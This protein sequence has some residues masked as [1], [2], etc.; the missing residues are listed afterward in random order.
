ML[1]LPHV[2]TRVFGTPL[3]VARPKLE[4]ILCV[5]APRFSGNYTDDSEPPRGSA[6][7]WSV[8]MEQIAVVSVIGTLVSRSGY[9][10]AASGLI[11]YADVGEA[12]AGAMAAPNVRGVV[13]DVD[14]SGG[15]VG[16]L[17]DLVEQIRAIRA[18][19]E[20]PL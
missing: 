6:P 7:L 18:A 3:M 19:S 11:S 12:I 4:A 16:G 2:A 13:L 17:F 1:H 10:E 14:F 5:L 20:K 9:L 8:A 15:E